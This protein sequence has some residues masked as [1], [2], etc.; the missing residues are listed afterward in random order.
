MN[1][2]LSDDEIINIFNEISDDMAYDSDLGG[3]S[4]AE[5]DLPVQTAKSKFIFIY[6]LFILHNIKLYVY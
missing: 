3:D 2:Q 1:K 4:D 5:Y 6:N